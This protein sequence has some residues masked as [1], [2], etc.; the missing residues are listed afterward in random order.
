MK[1]RH[2]LT[3]ALCLTISSTAFGQR[4]KLKVG[5]SA[6]GLDIASWVKGD[7]VSIESGKVYIIEFWATW[8]GPCRLTV[9]HLTG[10]QEKYGDDLVVIGISDEEESIVSPYVKTQGKKMNYR[11]AVDRRKGTT[12]AWFS[13]AGLKGIPAAFI[14]DQKGKIAFIGNPIGE[15]LSDNFKKFDSVLAKVMSGRYNPKLINDAKPILKVARSNRKVLNWR[16]A[17]RQYD[18][19]IALDNRV[20][21][22]VAIEKFEMLLV[23]MDDKDKAYDYASELINRTYGSD[24]GALRMLAKDIILNPRYSADPEKDLRDL[25]VALDAAKASLKVDGNNDP[26]ALKTLALVHF[27]RQEIDEAIERQR[28][29]FFITGTK[30]KPEYKRVLDTYQQAKKRSA[31]I[32]SKSN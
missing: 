16:M 31:S 11:I 22:D 13:R 24:A 27:H 8:C 19:V 14:V 3:V 18:R 7:S 10:L 32:N 30:N 21:A 17:I 4:A 2:I 1:F 6:P 23:E 28:Q 26:T 9:P 15:S 29:A 12:R 20:F 25:D 5:D